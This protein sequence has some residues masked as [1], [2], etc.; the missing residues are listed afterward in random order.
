M[1]IIHYLLWCFIANVEVGLVL[2]GASIAIYLYE[3]V[4]PKK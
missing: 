4:R 1:E 2:L 3:I